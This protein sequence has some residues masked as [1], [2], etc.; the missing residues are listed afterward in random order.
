MTVLT[1]LQMKKAEE[2]GIKEL[3][4]PSLILMENAALNIVNYIEES[5]DKTKK[6]T[7]FCG[8][9]NN[10]GDGF[11]I[12][13]G[14]F[15]RGF[16]TLIFPYGDFEKATEDC[17]LNY[18]TAK[19]MNIPFSEDLNSALAE[20]D[21][22]VD[23][24]AGTGLSS[25]LR[26]ELAEICKKIN[27]SGKYVIAAD[28]PTGVNSDSGEAY[29]NAIKAD[30]TYTFHL[31]KAGL[32]LFPARE[33]TGKLLTGSIGIPQTDLPNRKPAL[34][35]LTKKDAK[36]MLPK[37]S[38]SSHK[39][40]YGHVYAF[41]GSSQMTGAAVLN[42]TAAYRSGVGLVYGVCTQKTADII[43]QSLTEAVTK[44]VPD[45]GGFL[46]AAAYENVKSD[47]TEKSVVLTGSGLGVTENTKALIRTLL[48]EIRGILIIDADGIN[49]LAEEKELLKNTKARVILTPHIGE[50]S[51]LCGKTA[52][53]IKKD[54]INTAL[55]FAAEYK[56]VVVLKDA[57]TVTASP[58]GKACINITGTP[59]M[60]K[61]GSGDVLAG[62]IAGLS[63]QGLS[64]YD[65]ACLGTY[66][67]GL[68]AEA[69]EKEKG[70]YGLLAGE[71]CGF[72][73]E[74]MENL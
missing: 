42:L 47:L 28:C 14:L 33:Y 73:S 63:A 61:G 49:C 68:S 40:T 56:A 3:S 24:L 9:G 26:Q 71:T 67:N 2:I 45:E 44:I 41:S 1:N 22:I 54:P 23:A 4:V 15:S 70:S 36:T 37:R 30:L 21:I 13:R 57:S 60:S 38:P 18:N 50:M 65:A 72:I 27:S 8:K 64:S 12:A 43:H 74:T 39:G 51:R 20:A 5:F 19:A 10:G 29:E 17:S 31:P 7:V 46:T 53:E 32:L 58:D 66:I 6:I 35:T 48:I 55:N 16:N 59:A 69:A 62:I 34:K 25:S 11:A 52:E